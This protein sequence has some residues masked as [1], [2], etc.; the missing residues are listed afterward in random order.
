[1]E[2]KKRSREPKGFVERLGIGPM[3]CRREFQQA[4]PRLSCQ[5][6]PCIDQD[7]ADALPARIIA[8]E[9]CRDPGHG[10]AM[11]EHERPMQG[12][13]PDALGV[14]SR[15]QDR[16][17]RLF[18]EQAQ[19]CPHLLRVWAIP[20]LT[21]LAPSERYC[22]ERGRH[23]EKLTDWA[24]QLVLQACRW[25][26]DRQLVV[27]GDS[28]F[29]ASSLSLCTVIRKRRILRKASRVGTQFGG[30]VH[31]VPCG[32]AVHLF[33]GDHPDAAGLGAGRGFRGGRQRPR[34]HGLTLE[35]TS[36]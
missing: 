31:P 8:H 18:R 7:A 17:G 27:M 11:M 13:Q 15:K 24:R 10:L 29:A 35:G 33:R 2:A 28:G 22:H 1:M 3:E 34:P 23:H 25:L 26:P 16:I 12:D 36:A 20:F 4:A 19:A 5:G 32:S 30:A 9:G 14:F 21:A 6:G